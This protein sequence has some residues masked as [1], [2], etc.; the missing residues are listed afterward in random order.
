[1]QYSNMKD[2]EFYGADLRG[3][4]LRNS[5][6]NGVILDMA[7]LSLANLSSSELIDIKANNLQACPLTLPK[8]WICHDNSLIK[9]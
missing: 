6:L 5:S 8:D 3:A 2:T 9:N 4:D 1:M 7:N